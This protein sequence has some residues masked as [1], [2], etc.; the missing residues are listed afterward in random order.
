MWFLEFN[1]DLIVLSLCTRAIAF[2]SCSYDFL[3]YHHCIQLTSIS[4][5]ISAR[6]SANAALVSRVISKSGNATVTFD[7]GSPFD[8]VEKAP[9]GEGRDSKLTIAGVRMS[10]SG[11]HSD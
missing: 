6:E 4:D 7:D 1:F 2:V 3:G 5:T 8:V 9:E 10:S 11:M